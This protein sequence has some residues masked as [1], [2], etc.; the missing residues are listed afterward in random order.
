MEP[1]DDTPTT[2]TKSALRP[3]RLSAGLLA[4]GA[5]FA[6]VMA[7]LGIAAAQ[8]DDG[9]SPT[10]APPAASA[11]GSGDGEGEGV[12]P[13]RHGHRHHLRASLTVAAEVLG[14]PVEDLKTQLQEGKSLATIAGEKTDEL[15]AALVADATTHLQD[16][17]THGRLTQEEA[18]ARKATLEERVTALVNRTP[19]ADGE[20][21]PGDGHRHA[22]PKADLGVAAGVL[23]ISEDEIRTQLQ[24]GNSLATIAGDKTPALIDALVAAGNTRIDQA[25]TDGKLTQA[26]ADEKKAGLTERITALV[27]RTPGEGPRHHRHGPR[28]GA[29][30]P[31]GGPEAEAAPAAVTA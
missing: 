26:Q 8:T 17:V 7:G 24:A 18:D 30:A 5:T 6:M 10:T 31:E 21:P 9:S 19:P 1:T 23:G 27:N 15:I 25:V 16:A 4:G 3:N 11:E 20:R 29:P 12:R 22:G 13:H 14:V 28:P 2:P